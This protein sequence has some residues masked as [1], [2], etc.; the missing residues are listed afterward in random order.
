MTGGP[1]DDLRCTSMEQGSNATAWRVDASFGVFGSLPLVGVTFDDAFVLL[2]ATD[3][4]LDGPFALASP[5][6]ATVLLASHSAYVVGTTVRYH[7]IAG[8]GT[9]IAATWR[10]SR[11]C[12][13]CGTIPIIWNPPVPGGQTYFCTEFGYHPDGSQACVCAKFGTL[14]YGTPPVTVPVRE[15]CWCGPYG[16]AGCGGGWTTG[17]PPLGCLVPTCT[18]QYFY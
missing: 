15:V 10:N 2:D 7:N 4:A 17:L 16:A 9:T 1:L 18:P 13:F 12:W 5:L 14:T 11:P 3:G 8:C 6:D